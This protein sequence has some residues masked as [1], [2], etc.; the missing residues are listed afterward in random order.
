M[1][2]LWEWVE[3]RVYHGSFQ[4]LEYFF[5][6]YFVH[7]FWRSGLPFHGQFGSSAQA[8]LVAEV[9]EWF[10][11]WHLPLCTGRGQSLLSLHGTSAILPRK[12]RKETT[13]CTLN[14]AC[15]T[16]WVFPVPA[17]PT[18]IRNNAGPEC[19]CDL[20]YPSHWETSMKEIINDRAPQGQLFLLLL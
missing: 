19:T 6:L 9:S 12:L 8:E 10:G 1:S 5:R 2:R 17:S 16:N 11:R 15:R 7:I 18:S 20:N 3:K 4:D 14:S 13:S